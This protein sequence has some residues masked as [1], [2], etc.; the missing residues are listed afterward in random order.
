MGERRLVALFTAGLL[1]AALTFAPVSRA[2]SE[3]T[4][5]GR[6]EVFQINPG[7]S[8]EPSSGMVMTVVAGSEECN[9]PVEGYQ[10]TGTIHTRHVFAYGYVDPDTCSAIEVKG[11]ADHS[12]PTAH[13]LVVLRN[14]FTAAMNLSDPAHAGAFK[15]E[16]FSG[17]A[18]IRP[19]EGDCIK[20][21][22]TKMEAGWIG[23]W[24]GK[25]P[26]T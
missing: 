7:I 20:A 24:H 10:P 4:C 25:S 13:G 21:P 3:T 26:G 19:V 17:Q 22:M 18:V 16:R 6:A 15:G 12:I 14:H 1:G 11:W 5:I 2:A 8:M 9:G 23:H